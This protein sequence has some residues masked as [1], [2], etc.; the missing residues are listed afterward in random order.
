MSTE[1][2]ITE[3]GIEL[4]AASAPVANY[5]MTRQSGSLLFVSGHVCKRDGAV[6]TGRLGDSVSRDDGYALA[7]TTMLDI[8]AS[9][10]AALG[11]LDRVTAVIKISGF[12]NSTATFTEQS[13]VINGASDLLIEVFGE[14]RGRHARAAVGVAQ[15]PLGAAVELEAIFEVR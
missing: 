13:L 15:L 1:Q 14:D 5:A 7:R 4:P 12:V 6:V 3:L 9:A 11:S 8:L 2:R 10:R